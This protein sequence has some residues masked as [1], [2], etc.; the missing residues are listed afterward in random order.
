M[1]EK[2]VDLPV[3]LTIGDGVTIHGGKRGKVA[4]QVA[5]AVDHALEGEFE[6]RVH[7]I[8]RCFFNYLNITLSCQVKFSAAQVDRY[9]TKK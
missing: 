6:R 2:G 7:I 4:E 1:R 5:G 3:K 8:S 9:L